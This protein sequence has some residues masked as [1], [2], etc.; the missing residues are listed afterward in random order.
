MARKLRFAPPHHFL[1]ITQRGNYRQ[2]TFFSDS[3]RLWFLNILG[4]QA[5]LRQVE[6]LGYCLMPNHFHLI[7]VGRQ[8]ASI[9]KFMQGLNGQY[10]QSLNYR[11]DRHGRFWQDRYFSC[12]LDTTHLINALRYVELNPVRSK[13]VPTAANY[14]WSSARVHCGSVMSSPEWLNLDAFE[15]LYGDMD[16]KMALARGQSREELS[17]VRQATRWEVP[18]A[19]A[20]FIERLEVEFDRTLRR[21]TPG[22]P[23]RSAL[24]A[25]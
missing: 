20:E 2:R 4:R 6:I 12:I 11:L 8:D 1:H 15:S 17:E 13:I 3:D 19:S 22:R 14:H 16:W 10:A 5:S 9:S 18:L 24:A 21:G 7:A 23:S 25:A